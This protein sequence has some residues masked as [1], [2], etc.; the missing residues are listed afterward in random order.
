MQAVRKL[1]VWN[2]CRVAGVGWLSWNTAESLRAFRERVF[3]NLCFV[4][5]RLR[6]NRQVV[7]VKGLKHTDT[8][9]QTS[10]YM[11]RYVLLRE[12]FTWWCVT[13]TATTCWIFTQPTQLTQ[14]TQLRLTHPT[15]TAH[16]THPTQTTHTNSL[17]PPSSAQLT[18]P[19][20]LTQLIQLRLTHPTHTAHTTHPTHT[21]H[22]NS[23]N[24]HNSPSSPK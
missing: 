4:F 1:E 24:P 9:P 6:E 7:V 16:T 23:L 2:Q 13:A 22:S 20:Q 12:L 11:S 3:A 10:F 18:K 21:T 15:N 8:F 19:T 17:N 14:L 5:L